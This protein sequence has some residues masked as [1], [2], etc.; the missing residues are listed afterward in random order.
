[1]TTIE[2]PS[3]RLRA[4][5]LL[6][7]VMWEANIADDDT[8]AMLAYGADAP[9]GILWYALTPEEQRWCLARTPEFIAHA[10]A[11]FVPTPGFTGSES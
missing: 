11:T 1:M 7:L 2:K 8:G 9:L 10:L 5:L 6:E 3:F 4:Y